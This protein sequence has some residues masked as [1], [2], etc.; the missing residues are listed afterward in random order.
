M[1]SS[2]FEVSPAAWAAGT[3]LVDR[4]QTIDAASGRFDVERLASYIFR[5]C[6]LEFGSPSALADLRFR[7]STDDATRFMNLAR[8]QLAELLIF[9]GDGREASIV[10][11]DIANAVERIRLIAFQ[12]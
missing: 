12:A 8:A 2:D 6:P 10:Q 4:N 9:L 1:T 5:N 11:E 7:L 3:V